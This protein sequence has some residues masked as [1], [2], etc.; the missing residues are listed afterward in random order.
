MTRKLSLLLAFFMCLA[1]TES[2]AQDDKL[3]I[4]AKPKDMWVIGLNAGATVLAG[5]VDFNP[6]FGIGVHVRKSLDYIFSVRLDAGF[7]SF[8]GE[9]DTNTRPVDAFFYNRA[10]RAAGGSGFE[11]DTWKPEYSST[12]IAGDLSLVA[13]FNQIRMFKKNKI[14]PYGF[15]GL[16]VANFSGQVIDGSNEVEITD[17]RDFDE[18]FSIAISAVG[19]LGIDFR[20]NDKASIGI[21][22]KLMRLFGRGGDL[23]DGIEL[24]GT[25]EDQRNT[26]SADLVNYTNVRFSYA[27][28]KTEEKSVPLWWASPLDL[29]A[30]DLAE[31]KARPI[32]D[33]TD[34]D[35]D[36]VFDMV[37]KEPNTPE[38]FPV[39]TRGVSLDSDGD[40][41]VDGE[42]AEDFSPPGYQVNNK[43]VADVP[44]PVIL[45]E[46]DVNKLIDARLPPPVD[47]NPD[48]FLPMIFFDLDNYTVKTTEFAKLHNIATVMR[49]NPDVRVVAMGHTDRLAGNC[50]NDVLSFNRAEAAINYLTGKYNIARDRFVLNWGG[51]GTTLV[52]SNGGNMMN[53]RV[54]FT[55]ATNETEMA[56]PDCGVKKAGSGNKTKYSGN[57]EGGY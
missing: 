7:Y 11:G 4:S 28:G 38:G 51:E 5:D 20:L 9:E 27:L 48:W 14:G 36:G 34:S 35:G 24:Q 21:E 26:K 42:D 33:N 12:L 54:E 46:E 18:D 55:V 40:G 16:G 56:Q 53:R 49:L 1:L 10:S 19:G 8:S 44:Q 15:L 23:I 41:V 37:D 22:H 47:P 2:Y 3:K 43:G 32:F 13:N 6:N 30:E 29:L 50:Y 57:K 31:V 45:S 39:D 25:R 17:A 52:D